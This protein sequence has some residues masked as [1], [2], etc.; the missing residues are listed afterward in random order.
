M[1]SLTTLRSFAKTTTHRRPP[2][3]IGPLY[4]EYA[5]VGGGGGGG[6]AGGAGGGGGGFRSF[7]QNLSPGSYVVTIGGASQSC[8]TGNS[9]TFNGYTSAGGGGAANYSVRAAYSGGCGGG[10]HMQHNAHTISRQNG[11]GNVP[12]VSPSQGYD[13]AYGQNYANYY[14]GG[15]GGGGG[16]A[17]Q[18][19]NSGTGNGGY[20][21]VGRE[22]PAGSGTYY[23]GGGGGGAYGCCT[24]QVGGAGGG[25][26]G[27]LDTYR[28]SNND[29]DANTGGGGG[30]IQGAG[31]YTNGGFGGSG[32]VV[33]RYKGSLNQMA[34]G[35]DITQQG[36]YIVH[37][38]ISTGQFT[39][40]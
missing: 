34:T 5:I 23:S 9:T 40:F 24:G 21:G 3:I 20:G 10:G 27:T 26:N 1:N 30:G 2:Y 18:E 13:G 22:W 36:Q 19:A 8:E 37:R 12:S 32:I 31:D 39:V 33:I 6:A 28:N 17:G 11:Y 25:G 35:G 16:G 15:G 7:E 38:C 29:G 14:V 4:C